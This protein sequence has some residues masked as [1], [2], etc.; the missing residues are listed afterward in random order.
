MGSPSASIENSS[1]SQSSSLTTIHDY[2]EQT[3]TDV[4]EAAHLLMD[5]Y[6]VEVANL[7]AKAEQQRVQRPNHTSSVCPTPML[8]IN[9]QDGSCHSMKPDQ[10]CLELRGRCVISSNW[11]ERPGIRRP[12]DNTLS[13]YDPSSV[14]ED[15]SSDIE[16]DVDG[17]EEY[18][19]DDDST[20]PESSTDQIDIDSLDNL[21]SSSVI[22]SCL[23]SCP[24]DE[25]DD[26]DRD[27]REECIQDEQNKALNR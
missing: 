20:E 2:I 21:D 22:Q 24:Q 11:L 7:S 6:Q 9:R 3:E 12:I 25:E 23:A 15:E 17:V 27:Q 5:I 26:A 1:L 18:E 13:G 14:Y 4:L 16:M 8:A 10:D 19:N